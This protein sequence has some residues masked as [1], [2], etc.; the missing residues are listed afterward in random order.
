M[1]DDDAALESLLAAHNAAVLEHVAAMRSAML[2][3]AAEKSAT[4][5]SEGVSGEDSDGEKASLLKRN[6]ELAAILGHTQ[7]T[8]SE[9]E[10]NDFFRD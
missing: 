10:V 9:Q 3:A 1:A 7:K 5:L 2:S 6:M 8:I 4:E